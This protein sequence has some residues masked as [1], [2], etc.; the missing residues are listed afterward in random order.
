M[1][2]ASLPNSKKLYDELEGGIGAAF[3]ILTFLVL[4]LVFCITKYK[5]SK[6][7]FHSLLSVFYPSFSERQGYTPTA[8]NQKP[9]DATQQAATQQAATQQAA[10]KQ[11]APQQAANQQAATQ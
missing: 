4:L 8:A 7:S 10:T 1:S 11:A 5:C 2:S 6:E 9:A 3:F